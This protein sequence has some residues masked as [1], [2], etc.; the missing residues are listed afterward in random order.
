[1]S[2]E[3]VLIDALIRAAETLGLSTGSL[4]AVEIGR[5]RQK[6]HGDLSSNLAM[7]LASHFKKNPRQVA[8]ELLRHLRLDSGLILKTEIAGP[9]FINF[10]LNPDYFFE[11]LRRILRDGKKYGCSD[12][13][14]GKK[15]QVEFVSAN[16]TGPLTIGHGRQ[17]VIG[18]TIARLLEATGHEVVREYYFNDAGRQ[19]RVLG[20]SVRLRYLELIGMA[21]TFPDEYYQGAYIREIAQKAVEEKG[22][23]L[24]SGDATDYFSGLAEQEIF[25]LIRQTLDRLGIR[26][27]VFYNEKSLYETGKIDAVLQALRGKDLAYEADGATWFRTTRFGMEQDRVIV[28]STGEPTYRLPDIAYHKDKMDRG[29]DLIVDIFGADHIATYPDVLAGMEAL[30]YDPSRVKVLI[31]QFVTLTEGREKIK[32]ST[33][34]ANFV[35]LD[36]LMD[37]VGAD[38]TRYFFLNR[39]MSSHL[40]FDLTL[41]KT[42][43]DEN[44]VYYVQYAHARISSILRKA[45]EAGLDPDGEADLTRLRAPEEMDLIKALGTFPEVVSDAAEQF[46]PHRIPAYLEELATLYH[47]F[48]HAGKEDES[49]RVLSKDREA[50][51][52]RLALCR[53]TRTVLANGL[54]LLGISKPEKM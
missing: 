40:N 11:T 45:G 28:K 42:Q 38:V 27:D 49:L 33:R 25:A 31:H 43:S 22:D 32:M 8:E 48:Q 29:F 24:K 51:Q 30:G 10:T 12:R 50:S 3:T 34:K 53:A 41:A 26:F 5:P 20:D 37:E 9:G 19:M 13:G 54:S 23:S 44:P 7:V 16:P 35:T 6:G 18:D 46:E 14:K 36:E 1:M 4:P 17:A 47:R 15:T 2:V 21:V 39:S 52:A